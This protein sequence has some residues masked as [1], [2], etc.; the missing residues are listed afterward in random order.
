[1]G[2]SLRTA[3]VGLGGLQ[4]NSSLVSTTIIQS[5]ANPRDR[6]LLELDRQRIL[7][8]QAR[9]RTLLVGP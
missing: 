1:M 6:A 7:A 3:V 9:T 4:T 8:L 5:G 2:S